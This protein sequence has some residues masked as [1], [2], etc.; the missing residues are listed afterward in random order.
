MSS[1]VVTANDIR[2]FHVD[3]PQE[4]LDDLRRR[5]GAT[6]WPEKE[7]VPD[8]S[9]GVPLHDP[10]ARALL[11]DRLRLAHVRGEAQR[12]PAVPD[13]DRRAGHPFSFTFGR[14]TRTRCR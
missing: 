1:T 8:E 7:T 9:Q 3:V 10:E 12:P 2:P 4:E 5:I 14:S 13:R 6:N 11:D